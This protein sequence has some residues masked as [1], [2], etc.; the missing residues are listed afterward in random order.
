M[1]HTIKGTVRDLGWIAV[2]VATLIALGVAT[3]FPGPARWLLDWRAPYREGER[4]L[5]R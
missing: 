2:G 5:S 3:V 1:N 4:E